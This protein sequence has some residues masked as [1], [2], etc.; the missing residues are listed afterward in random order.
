MRGLLAILESAVFVVPDVKMVAS[1][2][3]PP[4]RP[5]RQETLQSEA[6]AS[7]AGRHSSGEAIG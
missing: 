7:P 2:N 5:I 1:A 3:V 6:G 4:V